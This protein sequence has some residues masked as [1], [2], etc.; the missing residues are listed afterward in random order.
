MQGLIT[1]GILKR[2]CA[3]FLG[4]VGNG[5]V[6]LLFQCVHTQL[7]TLKPENSVLSW[8]QLGDMLDAD[9]EDGHPVCKVNEGF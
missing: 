5:M 2:G 7:F 6:D 4:G 9:R 3:R 8:Y 1:H